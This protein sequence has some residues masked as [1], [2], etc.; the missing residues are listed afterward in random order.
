MRFIKKAAAQ[1]TMINRAFELYHENTCIKWIKRT[2]ELNYVEIT[3]ENSGCWSNL[4]RILNR[5]QINLQPNGCLTYV[6]TAIHE[7]MHT[8][9]FHHEQTRPDRDNYVRIKFENIEAGKSGNFNMDHAP[10]TTSFGTP[11]DYDSVM[12]YTPGSF[13]KNGYNTIEAIV[14]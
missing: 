2:N 4:G 6:G 8:L 12:H 1:L 7:M 10:S 3:G 5:Q 11:Y 9:G 13:S 14:S